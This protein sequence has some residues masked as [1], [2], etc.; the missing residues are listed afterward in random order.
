[1]PRTKQAAH[2]RLNRPSICRN[3]TMEKKEEQKRKKRVALKKKKRARKGKGSNGDN[4]NRKGPSVTIEKHSGKG[5]SVKV[6]VY[7]SGFVEA[8]KTIDDKIV[9]IPLERSLR[10]EE[11]NALA[12]ASTEEEFRDIASKVKK[13]DAASILADSIG[14]LKTDAPI[15]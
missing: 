13:E 14:I 11:L 2:S 3:R 5:T 9:S 4:N 1:M 15:S 7:S 12:G 8:I 10:D 6:S